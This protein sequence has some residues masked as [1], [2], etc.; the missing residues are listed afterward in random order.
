MWLEVKKSGILPSL[1]K[2]N[3]LTLGLFLLM[4]SSAFATVSSAAHT[5]YV[6]TDGHGFTE[7]TDV[8][9]E[10]DA[11][12]KCVFE[13]SS[14]L[15]GNGNSLLKEVGSKDQADL[16]IKCL[17]K[18]GSP[19][20]RYVETELD[21]SVAMLEVT[22]NATK[23]TIFTGYLENDFGQAD[24]RTGIVPLEKIRNLSA[25][26]RALRYLGNELNQFHV[27]LTTF[28]FEQA[29]TPPAAIA[30]E[31]THAA[32]CDLH[33]GQKCAF[34]DVVWTSL[35][36]A[37]HSYRAANTALFLD[38]KR[39]LYVYLIYSG[40]EWKKATKVCPNGFRLPTGY[41]IEM[42]GKEGFPNQDSELVNLMRDHLESIDA[43]IPVGTQI[44][45]DSSL[46]NSSL[47]YHYTLTTGW[48]TPAEINY[49]N[50]AGE[51]ICV[52]N[53]TDDSVLNLVESGALRE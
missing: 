27:F 23:R 11:R 47:E 45:S 24:Y 30:V 40:F 28:G 16:S 37:N 44:Y 50:T 42:N 49:S 22:S 5:F 20:G 4:S 9:L 21:T 17:S 33:P 19:H 13:L 36:I 51:V 14:W 46:K 6:E 53:K 10:A 43:T 29:L 15:D 39:D 26:N 8:K 12:Q 35:P 32:Y 18:L 31:G 41:P 2:N 25:P 3:S 48:E 38:A 7:H 52:K 1:M 34:G